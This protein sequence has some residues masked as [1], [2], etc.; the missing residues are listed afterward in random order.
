MGEVLAPEYRAN[1]SVEPEGERQGDEEPRFAVA[2]I[3]P[4][5]NNGRAVR[6]LLVAARVA[7]VA[8]VVPDPAVERVRALAGGLDS[9][10]AAR[11]RAHGA[12]MLLEARAAVDVARLLPPVAEEAAPD[13]AI[14]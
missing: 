3:E 1:T 13:R 11:Q 2:V 6:Q 9:S 5:L 14:H 12:L 4:A 10:E 7:R 8:N